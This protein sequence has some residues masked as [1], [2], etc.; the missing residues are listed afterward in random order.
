M[1]F[2]MTEVINSVRVSKYVRNGIRPVGAVIPDCADCDSLED[3]VG[4]P[5]YGTPAMDR[6]AWFSERDPDTAD[7]AGVY[8]VEVTGLSGSTNV[9]TVEERVGDGGVIGA[10]SAKPRTIGVTADLVGHT[11]EATQLG[12]EWLSA[13]LHPPCAES[14]DCAGDTLH[15]FS[16]CPAACDGMTDPNAPRETRHY[17]GVEDFEVAGQTSVNGP[18]TNVALNPSGEGVDI[19]PWQSSTAFGLYVAGSVGR[20]ATTNWNRVNRVRL[21]TPV[22]GPGEGTCL[23]SPVTVSVTGSYEIS[24]AV[25]VPSSTTTNVRL[26]EVFTKASAPMVTKDRWVRMSMRMD[27]VAG[28][29]YY[30]GIDTDK[31]IS[32]P[33]AGYLLYVDALQVRPMGSFGDNLSSEAPLSTDGWYGAPVFGAV[34][35]PATI[36]RVTSGPTAKDGSPG[37]IWVQ[38]KPA[39]DAGAV[40]HG[41]YNPAQGLVQGQVYTVS[42]DIYVPAGS[43]DV[44]TDVMFNGNGTVVRAKDTWVTVVHTFM[45]KS[46]EQQFGVKALGPSG[47]AGRG[48]Y[49]DN[50]SISPG[51]APLAG[52][53]GGSVTANGPSRYFDGASASDPV[54]NMTSM[55]SVSA[56]QGTITEVV[57]DQETWRELSGGLIA[58]VARAEVPAGTVV[59]REYLTWWEIK[60]PDH[61]PLTITPAW[62]NVNGPNVTLA[63]SETLR[64]YA[65][66]ASTAANSVAHLKVPAGRKVLF[67][68]VSVRPM[69]PTTYTWSG[70]AEASTSLATPGGDA[71]IFQPDGSSYI[72][73]GP[74]QIP[75]CDSVEIAWTVASPTGAEFLVRVGWADEAGHVLHWE[76][77]QLI[78]S[79]PMQLVAHADASPGF[80]V[81]WRPVLYT[82][83]ETMAHPNDTVTIFDLS[84]THRPMLTVEECVRPYR[85]TFFNVTTTEGPT[86]VEWRTLGDTTD[87][88]TVAR[89]EWTWVATDPFAWHDPVT[90]ASSSPGYSAPGVVVSLAAV[91]GSTTV[92]ARPAPS[93]VNCATDPSTPALVM[94]PLAPAL[95]D[96][97]KPATPST[98]SRTNLEIPKE[99]TPNGVG[100]FSWSFSN[101]GTAKKGVRVRIYEDL[102]PS[103]THPP[104]CEFVQEFWIYYLGPNQTIHIDGPGDS[105]TVECGTDDYNRPIT[106]DGYLNMRGA[107]GGPFVNDVVG[108]G[109]A[110]WVSIDVPSGQGSLDYTVE[111]TRRAG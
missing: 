92:C 9:V 3:A 36:A 2:G 77:P 103:S 69:Q 23:V 17:S 58:G 30:L 87:G 67:R 106:A 90:V 5:T 110:Y 41:T 57:F 50:L 47:G 74:V 71:F 15:L 66:A 18:F 28:Q 27:L 111:L 31:S 78:G 93:L 84:V 99:L 56:Q 63:P 7:F 64:V 45:A 22:L 55:V 44:Q 8:A 95:P 68:D 73:F 109:R 98:F 38:W 49:L 35:T 65:R 105:V 94:P 46:A 19:S 43:P 101:D 12:I 59:G 34:T 51:F 54:G 86:V 61:Q 26:V 52:G 32:P 25:Y 70:A 82:Y 42:V 37:K 16:T 48:V 100:K 97:A 75:V 53:A 13:V 80:P 76:E 108:C 107:Y 91:T 88:S 33:P 83:D 96:P 20:Q 24:L 40:Q 89:V 72:A 29:T 14:A 104:E 62:S 6:P 81:N 11:P 4:D 79:T 10:R 60:N 39:L 21:S 85:R 1:K 102:D